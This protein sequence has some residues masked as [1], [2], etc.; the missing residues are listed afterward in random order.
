M[1]V[2][3]MCMQ[4]L[5]QRR[6]VPVAQGSRGVPQ[7]PGK[8]RS[9]A[10]AE[11]MHAPMGGILHDRRPSKL[12]LFPVQGIQQGGRRVA[13]CRGDATGKAR[14]GLQGNTARAP[15]ARTH[16]LPARAS[17]L[18]GSIPSTMPYTHRRL[19]ATPNARL[20]PPLVPDPSPHTHPC[21]A[22][23]PMLMTPVRI[24]CTCTCCA[25]SPPF[26]ASSLPLTLPS[27]R[28]CC[29]GA[30]GL[31][32]THNAHP[33][34]RPHLPLGQ[35]GRRGGADGRV[36]AGAV[37]WLPRHARRPA[38]QHLCRGGGSCCRPVHAHACRGLGAASC[39]PCT[40]T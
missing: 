17:V 19:C 30:R 18:D 6:A 24:I 33:L 31:H 32:A 15:L 40:Q 27:A 37:H 1:S 11:S 4:E 2:R 5:F 20:L 39:T 21:A 9:Q 29:A 3:W 14:A 36:L 10:T 38:D 13:V 8:R 25:C 16:Y 35:G 7:G 26:P 12:G 22:V 34:P 23:C 28:R